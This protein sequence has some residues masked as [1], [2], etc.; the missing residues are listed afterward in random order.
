MSIARAP[1]NID[2]TYISPAAEIGPGQRTG[3]YRTSDNTLLTDEKGKSFISYED[4]AKAM[5]DEI[6]R[7]T[8]PRARMAVGY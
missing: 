4:Y 8:H 6:E 5:L 1:A 3:H 2:W 7:P